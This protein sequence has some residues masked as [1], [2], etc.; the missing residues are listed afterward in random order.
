MEK[1]YIELNELTRPYLT[2]LR[3]PGPEDLKVLRE[4]SHDR[5]WWS[6]FKRENPMEKLKMLK[7]ANGKG[8]SKWERYLEAKTKFLEA[9]TKL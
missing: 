3:H 9:E 2:S 8:T 6:G 5:K 4:L 7:V 1:R